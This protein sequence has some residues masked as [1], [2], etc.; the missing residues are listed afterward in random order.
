MWTFCSLFDFILKVIQSNVLVRDDGVCY[1]ADFGLSS[2]EEEHKL[3]QSSPSFK[4]T[5]NWAAPEVFYPP[6]SGERNH[7]AADV[8]ALGCTIYEVRNWTFQRSSFF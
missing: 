2:I 6:M 5:L 3:V 8:Y 4:G 7:R 1:L